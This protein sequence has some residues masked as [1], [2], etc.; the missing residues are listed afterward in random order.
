MPIFEQVLIG[1][2]VAD[3][4]FE[5]TVGGWEQFREKIAGFPNLA[6]AVETANLDPAVAEDIQGLLLHL[7]EKLTVVMVS[8]DPA[9][10]SKNVKNVVC[11]NRTVAIHPTCEVDSRMLGDLY[12]GQVRMVRHDQHAE[13]EKT[14]D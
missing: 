5:H 6:I 3:F 7:N 8:H 14:D 13:E 10:V 1:K 11:V 9:L 2:I 4:R 12:R